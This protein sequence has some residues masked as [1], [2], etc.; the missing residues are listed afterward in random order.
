MLLV[1]QTN[2]DMMA[3]IKAEIYRRTRKGDWMGRTEDG[4][5]L[6]FPQ[7]DK[8]L[9]IGI[10]VDVDG[11]REGQYVDFP[12]RYELSGQLRHRAAIAAGV[13]EESFVEHG[14]RGDLQDYWCAI[15]DTG[16]H[17]NLNKKAG[18]SGVDIGTVVEIYEIAD[19]RVSRI[20]VNDWRKAETQYPIESLT[21]GQ[22]AR[23]EELRAG[24]MRDPLAGTVALNHLPFQTVVLDEKDVYNSRTT[25][26]Y[27]PT[28][29]YFPIGTRV[30]IGI[31]KEQDLSK[32]YQI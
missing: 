29:G 13:I 11:I 27:I 16:K 30:V 25:D 31:P 14:R 4:A 32:V 10:Y 6:L 26:T 8:R 1:N 20:F 19:N 23:V 15:T 9:G 24:F 18:P 28:H 17:M 22:T 3:I 5:E 12:I 2:G 21:D 7:I